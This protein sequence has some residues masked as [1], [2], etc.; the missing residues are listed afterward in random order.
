MGVRRQGSGDHRRGGR[1]DQFGPHPRRA[2][3]TPLVGRDRELSLLRSV[4]ERATA[5]TRPH[6]VTVIGPPGIGKSR[7]SK[8]FASMVEDAGG[9]AVRGRCL[10][11]D[12]RDVYGAFAHQV[13]EIAGIF[14]QDPPDVARGKLVE[15]LS[16]GLPSA[17]VPEITRASSL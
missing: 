5:E 12:T 6:L 13:K 10:P 8:E 11:Y 16:A 9:R 3:G 2:R 7:L 4:W 14:E 17:E 15:A 1:G